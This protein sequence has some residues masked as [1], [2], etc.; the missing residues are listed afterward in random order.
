MMVLYGLDVEL[1]NAI[2]PWKRMKSMKVRGYFRVALSNR[3][4]RKKFLVHRLVL[5][6]FVGACPDGYQARHFPDGCR[7]NNALSNLS[8]STQSDNQRDRLV[9]GTDIR[10]EKNKRSKLTND[11]V[12]VIR[13]VCAKGSRSFRSIARE[14]GVGVDCIL[15][16][17]NRKTWKHI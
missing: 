1:I 15:D 3:G 6:A 2:G 17:N 10:G 5:L 9:H 13:D 12:M 7:S 4:V 8:W 16:I 14:F 11:R